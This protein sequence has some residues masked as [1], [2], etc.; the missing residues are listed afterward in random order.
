MQERS[1]HLEVLF[2][3]IDHIEDA[4]ALHFKALA[5]LYEEIVNLQTHLIDFSYMGGGAVPYRQPMPRE[6]AIK[7]APVMLG[8]AMIHGAVM[9]YGSLDLYLFRI[10][11]SNYQSKEDLDRTWFNVNM[12]EIITNV[13]PVT[14]LKWAEIDKLHKLWSHFVHA[15]DVTTTLT[16]SDADLQ[17]RF[18]DVRYFAADFEAAL[19]IKNPKA[20]L[21]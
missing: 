13:D 17:T 19:I 11:A 3:S 15:Y 4:Y 5:D 20:R 9:L 12:L 16:I 8:S 18:Q 7:L 10:C 1:T 6:K 2:R 21:R 14:C